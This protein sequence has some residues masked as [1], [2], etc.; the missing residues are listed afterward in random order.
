MRA[1]AAELFLAPGLIVA[2]TLLVYSNSLR[3]GF[4]W[5]DHAMIVE[6]PFVADPANLR[7]LL[8]P[9]YYTGAHAVVA[10]TRPVFVGSLLIDRALWGA[11]PAGYHLTSVLLHAANGVG[12]YCV[13]SALLGGPAPLLAGLLFSLHPIGTEAVDAVSFRSD[14]LAALFVLA[15]LGL[16][17]R[18]RAASGR[19]ALAWLGA[20]AA[21]YALGLLSK[22]MAAT[23]PLLAL[24]VEFC[25]PEPRNRGRRVSAALAAYAAVALAYLAFWAPRFGYGP[26][27]NPAGRLAAT[28]GLRPAAGSLPIEGPRRAR[29]F[30]PSPSPWAEL[31]EDRGLRLRAAACAFAD[32]F[33]WLAFPAVLVADRA[34]RLAASW[35]EAGAAASLVLLFGLAL[36][37]VLLLRLHPAGGFGPAWCLLTLIPVSGILPLYNPVAERYLY[38]VSAGFALWLA[39]ALGEGLGDGR[40]RPLL[41]LCAAIVL[42]GY[43]VGTHL[44]NRDWKS[45]ATLFLRAPSPA[46]SPR[47][48]Y[49]RA[50][51]LWEQGDLAGGDRELEEALLRHPRFA[52]GWL[53]L[54]ASRSRAGRRAEAQAAYEKALE[55]A[56]GNAVMSFAF[57]D[58]LAKTGRPERATALY[59]AA[60]ER[61]PAYLEAWVNLAAL[62]RDRKDYEEAKRCYREAV[63]L[64]GPDPVPLFSYGLLLERLGERTEA[65]AMFGA[66]AAR[67][68]YAPAQ[69]A[70]KRLRAV[71][72]QSHR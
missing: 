27:M 59:R 72:H 68:G 46:L 16:Y 44:R 70:V 40:R 66:S 35:T 41:V 5:D 20:S 25:F 10:G 4:T 54:G 13:A 58:F 19:R 38:L 57:A 26:T 31:N 17:L 8:D 62:Y 48:L 21:C 12:L 67:G 71:G 2:A 28:L 14:L 7:H 33:R 55:L 39:W 53:A 43:A 11:D 3:N 9:R 22:E 45:D 34:P 47:A 29:H 18:A 56:P 6:N 50:L 15:G 52:E 51:L 63:A 65:E 32:Y 1:H 30:A 49:T 60:L 36:G 37:T 69:A 23:L 24:L 61:D 64:A 42:C